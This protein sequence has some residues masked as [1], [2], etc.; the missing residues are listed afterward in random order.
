MIQWTK[1]K[2]TMSLQ[3]QIARRAVKMAGD[4]GMIY[5]QMTA[6]M[7]IDACHSNVCPLNLQDLLDADDFNFAHDIIGI[8]QNI[9]RTTGQLQNCFVPRYAA[10]DQGGY[11]CDDCRMLRRK[12]NPRDKWRCKLWEVDVDDPHNS[13]CESFQLV[14]ATASK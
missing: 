13:H 12:Q 1:D 6:V 14:Q 5:D 4:N 2:D 7:D 3:S 11:G 8:M 10:E 9:D